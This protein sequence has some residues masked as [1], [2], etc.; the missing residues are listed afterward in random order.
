MVDIVNLGQVAQ[1]SDI[2][3]AAW[4]NAA[5][6]KLADLEQSLAVANEKLGTLQS[7][8]S[9]AFQVTR[10]AGLTANVAAGTIKIGG[11]VA[12]IAA[13]S[14]TCPDN[15]TSYVY[16]DNN[17][18]VLV[19]TTRPSGGYEIARVV[20]SGGQITEI[21]NYPLFEVRPPAINTDN[22][23]TIE[24]A[25]SRAWQRIALARKT[26]DFPIPA[27]DTYYRIPFEALE[28]NGFNTSGLFTAQTAGDFVFHAQ[29]R[30]T[31]TATQTSP[32][33]S[34][35][36]SLFTAGQEYAILGQTESAR[37]DL[38]INASNARPL[39]MTA[40]QTADLRIYLTRGVQT[41]VRS[42]YSLVQVWKL[43]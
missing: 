23:A 20:T 35:K 3:R 36:L 8:L 26:Q 12:S 18:Q 25:N 21:Q 6:R 41:S 4:I 37:G 29:I 30:V 1:D 13:L 17:A 14:I 43:P 10:S 34:A 32:D 40:G 16:I 15:S 28:G 9:Q 22:F 2:L 42:D 39:I 7:Q 33:M 11:I 5:S 38:T 31:T 19:A 24:Y 27:R